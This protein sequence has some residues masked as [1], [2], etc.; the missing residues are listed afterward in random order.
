M[1]FKIGINKR[2]T[3]KITGFI[4]VANAGDGSQVSSTITSIIAVCV[5]EG[6]EIF[7]S[8]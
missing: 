1:C 7:K 4:Q 3:V 8:R 5:P 2:A 6:D